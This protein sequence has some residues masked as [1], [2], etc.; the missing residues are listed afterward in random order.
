MDS[1]IE[2]P[3]DAVIEDAKNR[4]AEAC[5]NRDF[6]VIMEYINGPVICD[7]KYYQIKVLWNRGLASAAAAGHLDIVKLLIEKAPSSNMIID[8]NRGMYGACRYGH[9]EIVEFLI[10]SGAKDFDSGMKG[11]CTGGHLDLA[12]WLMAQGPKMIRNGLSYG[13]AAACRE[14]HVDIVEWL[15]DQ[16]ENNPELEDQPRYLEL[17]TLTWIISFKCACTRGDLTMIERILQ[18]MIK[19]GWI[20]SHI[21]ITDD[22]ITEVENNGHTSVAE[23]LRNF[24]R[25][26]NCLTMIKRAD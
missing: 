16:L 26:P 6:A 9:L 4:L 11:S 25:D 19:K 5:K 2:D 21:K 3:T 17:D 13:V 24:L 23:L 20:E 1:N 18:F 22:L 7:R 8:C 15:C 14:G 12:K 10:A